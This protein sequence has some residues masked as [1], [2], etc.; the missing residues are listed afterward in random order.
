M[1]AVSPREIIGRSI[2]KKKL[3]DILN[4]KKP[5]FVAI[6]GRRRVGKTFLIRNFYEK[7]LA[8]D[9]GAVTMFL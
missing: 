2:E 3:L 9:S 8:S 4:S 5:E 1:N 6:Y 7:R